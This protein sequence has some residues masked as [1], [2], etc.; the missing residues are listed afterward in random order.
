MPRPPISRW[1]INRRKTLF[2]PLAYTKIAAWM[3]YRHF[4]PESVAKQ[5]GY[6][7]KV[8]Q[9]W[10]EGKPFLPEE[11]KR[12]WL[13]W[14][15]LKIDGIVRADGLNPIATRPLVYAPPDHRPRA[16]TRAQGL[17]PQNGTSPHHQAAPQSEAGAS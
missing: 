14:K 12:L 10:M 1:K 9:G 3:L 2:W 7:V 15:I 16:A 13:I 11:V 8:V 4:S 5:T 17:K 6:S